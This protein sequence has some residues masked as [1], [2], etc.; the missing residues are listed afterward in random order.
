MECPFCNGSGHHKY[1]DCVKCGGTGEYDQVHLPV[2]KKAESTAMKAILIW[3]GFFSL[4]P[5][6]VYLVIFLKN[7][8]VIYEA[9]IIA[10]SSASWIIIYKSIRKVI[11]N[12]KK[13]KYE[14]LLFIDPDKSILS[15]VAGVSFMVAMAVPFILMA[16]SPV[17]LLIR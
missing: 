6:L 4:I 10:L 1:K 13:P 16:F 17:L 5:L 9:T 2:S 14:K 8:G 3:I 15:N 12:A 7:I 11:S